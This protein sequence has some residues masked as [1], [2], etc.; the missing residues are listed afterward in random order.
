MVSPLQD[1]APVAASPG[2]ERVPSGIPGL[3]EVIGGGLPKG[4]LTMLS[5]KCGTGKTTFGMQFVYF[6]AKEK[7]E[8]GI[9]VTLEKEPEELVEGAAAFPDFGKMVAEKKISIIRPDMH[10]FDS[11]KKSLEDEVSRTGAK[12]LVV[13]SFSLIS[14]YFHEDPYDVRRSIFELSRLVKRMGCTAIIAEDIQ[15][16]SPYLSY[17]GYKEFV[18]SDV[19]I[20]SFARLNFTGSGTS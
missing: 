2:V 8:Q 11:F 17:N 12:R 6:G 9:F 16:G 13:D 20:W 5:G 10:R 7:G 1:T 3:D 18:V 19:I 15:E 14:A 4:S